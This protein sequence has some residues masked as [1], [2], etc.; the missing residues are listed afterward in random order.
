MVCRMFSGTMVS[1]DRKM[2]QYFLREDTETIESEAQHAVA[3]I[4][5]T[6]A[7]VTDLCEALV[8]VGAEH[9]DERADKLRDWGYQYRD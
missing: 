1:N 7:Y 3:Q 2:I 9:V 6:D 4:L 5:D 8:R